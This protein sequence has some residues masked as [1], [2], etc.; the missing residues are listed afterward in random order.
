MRSL[1]GPLRNSHDRK[2]PK[3]KATCIALNVRQ[4]YQ[5][6]LIGACPKNRYLATCETCTGPSTTDPLAMLSVAQ[7]HLAGSTRKLAF[8]RGCLESLRLGHLGIWSSNIHSLYMRLKLDATSLACECLV[9]WH[10]LFQG[11]C[12]HVGHPCLETCQGRN[13]GALTGRLEKL[14]AGGQAGGI[15]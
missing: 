3:R 4:T 6:K 12:D 7:T 15:V 10:C 11:A 5:Q 14:S 8:G 1:G 9:V 13:G 2:L